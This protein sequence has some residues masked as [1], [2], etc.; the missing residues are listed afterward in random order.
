LKRRARIKKDA[1]DAKRE[2]E[3]EREREK[4]KE[5]ILQKS[6]LFFVL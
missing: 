2:R 1:Y 5:R 6:A 4:E 3:R